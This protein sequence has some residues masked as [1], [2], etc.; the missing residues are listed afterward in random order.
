[1]R[2]RGDALTGYCDVIVCDRENIKTS[3][4]PERQSLYDR[5]VKFENS[6][7]MKKTIFSGKIRPDTNF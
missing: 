3:L 5:K 6:S 4:K 2:Y 7:K 1:M